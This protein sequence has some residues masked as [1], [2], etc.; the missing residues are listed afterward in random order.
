MQGPRELTVEDFLVFSWAACVVH[1]PNGIIP[2]S[3]S[4][5]LPILVYKTRR[6]RKGRE[7]RRRKKG[8][9]EGRRNNIFKKH[10]FLFSYRKGVIL[11]VESTPLIP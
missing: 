6:G 1:C 11:T 4:K 5:V 9:K 8:T 10:Y 7:E 2:T 3:S